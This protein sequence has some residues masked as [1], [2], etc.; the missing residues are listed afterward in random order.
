MKG[1]VK[2]LFV[3]ALVASFPIMGFSQCKGFTKKQCL[4]ILEPYL[5][6][7]QLNSAVL[8]EGDVAELLLTFYGGQEYRVLVCSQDLIGKVEF[9]LLDTD[10]NEIFFNKEHDYTTNWD[11]NANSTQQLIIQVLVL[12]GA[13]KTDIANSGCVSIVVGFKEKYE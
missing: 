8:S 2:I 13:V 6:N 9:K 10:R 12:Q 5:Y 11:F 1:L 7:G 4:P 3:S